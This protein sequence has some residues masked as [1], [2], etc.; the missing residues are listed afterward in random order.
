METQDSARIVRVVLRKNA[1]GFGLAI[2]D[3]FQWTD[4]G[5]VVQ[6]FEH[7]PDGSHGPAEAAGI[8]LCQRLIEVNNV[9]VSSRAALQDV[10]STASAEAEFVFDVHLQISLHKK[11]AGFG[12]GVSED[13][14]VTSLANEPDGSVGP[15]EEAGVRIG[16]RI[17]AVRGVRV[18]T[19]A[20]L[21]NNLR[22]AKQEAEFVF[23]RGL[24][25]K[26]TAT[27]LKVKKRFAAASATALNPLVRVAKVA[28]QEEDKRTAWEEKKRQRLLD[29][30][31]RQEKIA[32]EKKEQA[33]MTA[34]EKG[35]RA[36]VEA[37]AQQN[38]AVV[39]QK[40]SRSFLAHSSLQRNAQA[41][42][43]TTIQKYAR[44]HLAHKTVRAVK[45]ALDAAAAATAAAQAAAARESALAAT[46]AR[47]AARDP[48]HKPA[49]EPEPVRETLRSHGRSTN[50]QQKTTPATP[51]PNASSW[52]GWLSNGLSQVSPFKLFVKDEVPEERLRRVTLRKK[53][54]GFGLGVSDEAKVL[55][56]GH[57]PDGS[58]G[59]AL[60]AEVR[61]GDVILEVNGVP[62]STRAQI[63]KELGRAGKQAE[64]LF[65][66]GEIIIPEIFE[67]ETYYTTV[68][69]KKAGGF[70]IG[71]DAKAVIFKLAREANGSMGAAEDVGVEI[72]DRI[73]QVCGISVNS[74][75]DL[76]DALQK[77]A[78]RRDVEFAS[79]ARA[80]DD[81]ESGCSP[82]SVTLRARVVFSARTRVAVV[83]DVAARA[84]VVART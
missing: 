37:E 48:D 62:V 6:S 81:G 30:Q 69:Q 18:E 29:I 58:K 68:L 43:V 40:H 22:V 13:N 21:L 76:L 82:R 7:E 42:A 17:V 23:E 33:G 19:K 34:Y 5:V 51:A 4:T 73:V 83:A 39:I 20:E 47:W 3:W 84:T 50:V 56:L 28:K 78:G 35:R 61:I 70:G 65:D 8:Q 80:G 38:A 59:P 55:K 10:L 75:Q 16:D 72:G 26:G 27:K 12:I 57:E 74:K 67:G 9:A 14:F 2:N 1:S 66:I 79:S 49:P 54:A 52:G 60:E 63:V 44:G 11:S 64:F 46:K 31:A 77:Q 32:Q 15:A 36:E 45:A 53:N 41:K 71:V 24:H 25:S